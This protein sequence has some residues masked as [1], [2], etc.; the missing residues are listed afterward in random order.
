VLGFAAGVALFCWRLSSEAYD[1]YG[2]FGGI[3]AAFGE[4]VVFLTFG[5]L[6]GLASGYTAGEYIY[7]VREQDPDS[8]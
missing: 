2:D 6:G 1:H 4:L 7:R 8:S 3:H 5:T